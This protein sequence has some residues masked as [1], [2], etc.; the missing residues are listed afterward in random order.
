MRVNVSQSLPPIQFISKHPITMIRTFQTIRISSVRHHRQPFQY[1][2]LNLD[3]IQVRILFKNILRDVISFCKKREKRQSN[4][5][6]VWI[7]NLNLS[8]DFLHKMLW[9]SL[10]PLAGSLRSPRQR[11]QRT[12]SINLNTTI[13][14][15]ESIIR[16]NNR[17]IYTAGRPP[18]YNCAGQQVEPFVIGLLWNIFVLSR[19]LAFNSFVTSDKN[20]K[21]HWAATTNN[22]KHIKHSGTNQTRA[23]F[24]R[25]TQ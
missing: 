2:L 3:Q 19:S 7:W 1:Q 24:V 8:E 15:T 21:K 12:T 13:D 10:C 20:I 5:E 6:C 9:N 23:L 17:T 18:W 16:A 4:L 14:A 22:V 11:R 25:N